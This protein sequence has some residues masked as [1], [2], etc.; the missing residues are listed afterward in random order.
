MRGVFLTELTEFFGGE[1]AGGVF[2]ND[3]NDGKD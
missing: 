3:Y 2:D 1:K